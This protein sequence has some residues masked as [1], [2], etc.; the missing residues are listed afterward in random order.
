MATGQISGQDAHALESISGRYAIR[1]VLGQ[2]AFAT[3][4]LAD[5]LQKGR[6]VVIKLLGAS[7]SANDASI[8]R[9]HAEVAATRLLQHKNLVRVLTDGVTEDYRPYLVTEYTRGRSL[10]AVLRESGRVPVGSAIEVGIAISEALA[11]I[12]GKGVVHRDL[13]PSNV[14][15]PGWPEAPD[16][17]NAK[18]LDFGVAGRLEQGGRTQ[19]GMIYGTLRYMSPEQ[20]KG[21]QQSPATDVYG[22]GLLLFEMLAGSAPAK[23]EQ[24]LTTL[25]IAIRDG[26]SEQDLK[27]IVPDLGELIQRCVRAD[28][29]ER[30]TIAAVL[31]E[32]RH[33]PHRIPM[34]SPKPAT[35]GIVDVPPAA[36]APPPLAPVPMAASP[37]PA[38]KLGGSTLILEGD[39]P[40]APKARAA[41]GPRLLMWIAMAVI[42]AALAIAV[43][44][45][46]RPTPPVPHPHEST[47]A[48]ERSTVTSGAQAP[49]PPPSN[50][51]TI[52]AIRFAAG[53]LL[54][55]ASVAIAW[56]LRRWLGSRSQV[57][58]QVYE[59]VF[60]AKM[61]TDL[62]ATIAMQLSDL[63]SKLRG[64]DER[65]LA[66]SVALMLDEYGAA[67]DT[68]DRQAALMNMVALSEKL[69]VRLSPW[70]ERYKEIIA[71]AVA[72][73]GGVSGLMTA[74]NSVLSQKH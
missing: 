50:D 32:L 30:P 18:L 15:I 17:R 34:E 37:S 42:T 9:F 60:G 67:T 69:A 74:I 27:S 13:K 45:Y 52:R 55:G 36:A 59:L 25:L 14:L 68:K 44:L 65:I 71:S 58:S 62:T 64:L 24:D 28:P 63:V 48:P 31:E 53:L 19:A 73:M 46:S 70:Y 39:P 3:V 11:Y 10:A 61:R 22:F 51:T 72:L 8:L 40:L 66:G 29:A 5:D 4:Y 41:S 33:S 12:H 21:E 47:S 2:G 43:I 35:T 16:Y 54:M 7:G 1:S 23:R 49:A 6:S 57:Q 56:G 26:I 20:I 38:Q